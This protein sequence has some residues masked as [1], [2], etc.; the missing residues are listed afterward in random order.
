MAVKIHSGS[1]TVLDLTFIP[2]ASSGSIPFVRHGVSD[3]FPKV[4]ATIVRFADLQEQWDCENASRISHAAIGAALAFCAAA[5]ESEAN[6]PNVYPLATGGILLEWLDEP[7]GFDIL[8]EVGHAG[9]S[10]SI[11][12][13]RNDEEIDEVVFPAADIAVIVPSLMQFGHK[14]QSTI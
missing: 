5:A 13:E 7:E 10:V 6:A 2:T 1:V 14:A 9:D 11:S 4:A 8:A 12:I 3:W